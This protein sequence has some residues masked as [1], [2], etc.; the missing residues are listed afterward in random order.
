MSRLLIIPAAGRGSR[1]G[2]N[3]PKALCPVAGRP[4]IDWLLERYSAFVDRVV[5]VVSPAAAPAFRPYLER[6]SPFV[7]CVLQAEPTGMLPAILCARTAIQKHR[8]DEVWITWC[9]QAGV[10]R[11]TVER[12]AAELNEHPGVACVFPTVRQEPPYIHF[13]RDSDGRIEGVRQRREGA[14]MPPVGESDAGLFAMRREAYLDD[15]VEYATAAP[16]GDGTHEQN[17]LPFLPWLAQRTAVRTF[18]VPDAREAIGVNTPDDLR[19]M[20]AYLRERG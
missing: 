12:L 8:P 14:T 15:L 4:M 2:W 18:D 6:R 1:L 16:A 10:S 7:E 9:D 20:E 13:V 17:F 19:A 5:V 11:K 3:G